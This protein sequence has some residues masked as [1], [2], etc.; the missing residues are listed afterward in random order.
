MDVTQRSITRKKDAKRR[1]G[2][3]EGRG[4]DKKTEERMS[5]KEGRIK[6]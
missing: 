5:M 3:E 4:E 2:R 6:G 1:E